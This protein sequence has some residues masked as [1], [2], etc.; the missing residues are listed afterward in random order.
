M[1]ELTEDFW[2]T[3]G[4]K[5]AVFRFRQDTNDWNSINS[6]LGEH[7]EYHLRD[8][9][10]KVALDIG[11]Y[12]GSVGIPIAID[13]PESKVLIVEPVPWNAEL[14]RVNAQLN[15]VAD[16]VLVFEG[17]VGPPGVTTSEIRFGYR[18]DLNLE[19]HAFVGNTSLAYDTGGDVEHDKLQ[20][21]TLGISALLDRFDI[22]PDWTKID[23]EGAEWAFFNAPADDLKRLPFIVGEAH[24]VR[25][26]AARDIL[27]FLGATHEVTLNGPN[28]DPGP[29]GFEAVRR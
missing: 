5:A 8:V 10:P 25:G 7:D 15:R 26:Y 28:Q 22:A 12:L 21:E 2:Q 6:C 19:H 20:V 16:R 4:G 23:C 29:C 24:P 13:H 14:I 27:N 1:Y 9:A 11:G 17:A 18:G 3:V